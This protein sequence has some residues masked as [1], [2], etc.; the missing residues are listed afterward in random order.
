MI[1]HKQKTRSL[2]HLL[3]VMLALVLLPCSVSADEEQTAVPDSLRKEALCTM[4]KMY[5]LPEAEP[6]E[7][8]NRSFLVYPGGREFYKPMEENP[9]YYGCGF[10]LDFFVP[11]ETWSRR[12]SYL[13]A[14][15]LELPGKSPEVSRLELFYP[16][17]DSFNDEEFPESSDEARLAVARDWA[18]KYVLLPE[19]DLREEWTVGLTGENWQHDQLAQYNLLTPDW[20]ISLWLYPNSMRYYKAVFYSR[21]WYTEE[22]KVS[23]V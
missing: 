6:D 19:E 20:E 2:K 3:A 23:T 1:G 10:F 16:R 7:E 18:Q 5:R 9:R 13:T 8:N 21:K 22:P 17:W 15:L 4:Q 11:N 14:S 12:P